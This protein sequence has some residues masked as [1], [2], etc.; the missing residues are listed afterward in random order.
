LAAS[1]VFALLAGYLAKDILLVGFSTPATIAVV[2]PMLPIGAA[3]YLPAFAAWIGLGMV[4]YWI[5]WRPA[6]LEA[7]T[8]MF[9]VVA[10]CMIGLLALYMR[11]NLNNVIVVFHP[12]EHCSGGRPWRSRMSR[13][14]PRV[15]HFSSR[16]SPV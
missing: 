3:I 10:G 16:P 7:L 2:L 13:P 12:M 1:A 5:V 9:A 6:P 14:A 4:A 8:A 15:S 11:Y